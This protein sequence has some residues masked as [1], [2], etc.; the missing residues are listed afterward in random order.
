MEL[1]TD[2]Q[3]IQQ[4]AGGNDQALET[5]I[6]RYLPL[7]YGFILHSI[8]E[9]AQS[10]DLT[11]EVFLKVWRSIKKYNP[12]KSFKTWVFTIA[13]RTLIDYYRKKKITT[14]AVING[15]DGQMDIFDSMPSEE[16]SALEKIEKGE[17]EADLE[18]KLLKLPP[19]DR[20]LLLLYY[21]E[22]ITFAEIAAMNQESLDTVKSRHRRALIKLRKLMLNGQ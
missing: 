6:Q 18:N 1:L 22:K 10:E 15:E 17:L 11:Q 8:G 21:G 13:R 2:E 19:D 7:V 3:L 12:E 16:L 4:Y 20:I 14:V 9:V 5:L